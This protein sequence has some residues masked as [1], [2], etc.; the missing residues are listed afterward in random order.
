MAV[1]NP[2]IKRDPVEATWDLEV[3]L[4]INTL[5]GR[6]QSLLRAIQESTD[7]DELKE[8]SKNI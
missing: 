7:I 1:N 6:L 4:T 3:T 2:P 8:L 5:E